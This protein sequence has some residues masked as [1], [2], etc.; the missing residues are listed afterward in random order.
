MVTIGR[1]VENGASESVAKSSLKAPA[2]DS[3]EGLYGLL[4]WVVGVFVL[5][6]KN[7]NHTPFARYLHPRPITTLKFYEV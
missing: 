7:K 4:L 1:S 2:N 5:E 6:I 3:H